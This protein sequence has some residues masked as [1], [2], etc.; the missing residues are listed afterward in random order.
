MMMPLANDKEL[1]NQ[2]AP[3]RRGSCSMVTMEKLIADLKLLSTS[4]SSDKPP[5]NNKATMMQ[6]LLWADSPDN[7]ITEKLSNQQSPPSQEIEAQ[8]QRA[9]LIIRNH[10]VQIM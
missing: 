1:V 9:V 8:K 2:P 4:S 7:E 10:M 5:N 3:V 6:P